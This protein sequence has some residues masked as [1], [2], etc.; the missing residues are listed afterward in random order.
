MA[1]VSGLHS[2]HPEPS[3][4][5]RGFASIVW[6][7]VGDLRRLGPG[8]ESIKAAL[9]RA[10]PRARPG[11]YPVWAGVMHRFVYEMSIGDLVVV[12]TLDLSG[13]SAAHQGDTQ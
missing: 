7:P 2:N 10:Y 8:R 1:T 12:S 13:P 11:G 9:E 6:G 4:V 3:P 5:E